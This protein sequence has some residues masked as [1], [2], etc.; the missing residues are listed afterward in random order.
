MARR[1]P[2]QKK[3]LSYAKDQRNTFGQND[4][5]SRKSIRRNKRMPNRADRHREHQVLSAATG[6]AAVQTAAEAAELA[7]SR[8]LA[9]RSWW[10]VKR[11]RKLRDAPLAEVV[12]DKL[13]RRARTGM[14]EAAAADARIER[15]RRRVDQRG[16]DL[17]RDTFRPS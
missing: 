1:T 17:L 12:A 2:Q 10:M 16:R 6:P 9:T 8:L 14:T 15:I 4:K 5:A 13:R 11:W 7:E 3:A